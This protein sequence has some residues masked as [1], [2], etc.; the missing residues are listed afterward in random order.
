[1]STPQR[2]HG[3]PEW[4]YRSGKVRAA[5][6]TILQILD[7]E[8][9]RS[10]W[11]EA[12][13]QRRQQRGWAPKREPRRFF[14]PPPRRFQ[15]TPWPRRWWPPF[16]GDQ[17]WGVKPEQYPQSTTPGDRRSR[18]LPRRGPPVAVMRAPRWPHQELCW[19][20]P[21]GVKPRGTLRGGPER[22]AEDPQRK[23]RGRLWRGPA[24]SAND[25]QL[26]HKNI[27]EGKA[28]SGRKGKRVSKT[29][30]TIITVAQSGEVR[31]WGPLSRTNAWRAGS[32]LED[33]DG[34]ALVF[35]GKDD[36]RTAVVVEKR[37][38]GEN[39]WFWFREKDQQPLPQQ[40]L[41]GDNQPTEKMRVCKKTPRGEAVRAIGRAD[42]KGS[43][44]RKGKRGI[45]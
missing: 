24:R 33:M 32:Y 19:R 7:E 30:P 10:E 35:I 1:M 9:R 40:E 13:R 15:E 38:S 42:G 3:P 21:R 27:T 37:I 23:P 25:P 29:R 36:E 11:C 39:E 16:G 4:A 45:E 17:R 12:N 22:S 6:R 31:N 43:L 44:P 18:V 20:Q 28:K 14:R 34:E 5:A 8:N 2:H 41:G 26:P